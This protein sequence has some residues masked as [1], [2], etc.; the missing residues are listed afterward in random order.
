MGRYIGFCLQDITE[1]NFVLRTLESM[2]VIVWCDFYSC[3]VLVT[4]LAVVQYPVIATVAETV[5]V[6]SFDWPGTCLLDQS[7]FELTEILLALPPRQ[8]N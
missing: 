5:S 2:S 6:S 4:Q 7:D 1:V 3:E 8:I